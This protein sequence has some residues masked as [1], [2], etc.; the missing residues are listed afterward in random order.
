[1]VHTDIVFAGSELPRDHAGLLDL[2]VTV[3]GSHSGDIIV[4]GVAGQVGDGTACHG[5]ELPQA[6]Q[7]L[8]R[9]LD[10]CP[11]HNIMLACQ[12]LH[13]VA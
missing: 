13:A 7:L 4:H 5:G 1:M 3:G 6:V 10:L 12:G 8:W 11:Y 9:E 2:P